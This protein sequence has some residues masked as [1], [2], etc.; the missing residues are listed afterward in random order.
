MNIVKNTYLHYFYERSRYSIRLQRQSR[1]R[2]STAAGGAARATAG[3]GGRRQGRRAATGRAGRRAAAMTEGSG[4]AGV[5]VPQ[6]STEDS[7][8]HENNER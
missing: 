6:S 2:W 3:Q 8:S 7:W 5:S 4:G 1:R